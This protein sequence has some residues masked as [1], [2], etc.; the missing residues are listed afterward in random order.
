MNVKNEELAKARLQLHQAC[1]L[2]AITGISFVEKQADDS[3]TNMEWKSELQ[4]FVSS[5]FGIDRKFILSLNIP[6]LKYQFFSDDYE[7]LSEFQLNEI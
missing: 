2:L 5:P 3:H 6:D 4:S 7:L 1:Q